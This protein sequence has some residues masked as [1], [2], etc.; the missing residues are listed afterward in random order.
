MNI[1][2]G[3]HQ[4]NREERKD[5]KN[6]KKVPQNNKCRLCGERDEMIDHRVSE[7][8]KLAQK[9]CKTKPDWEGKVIH[10]ELCKRQK[11]NRASK[12]KKTSGNK[13][14]WQKSPQQD[15]RLGSTPSKIL[16]TILKMN[17]RETQA[18]GP[19]NKEMDDYEE[20]LTHKR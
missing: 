11:F 4:R 2:S 8:C 15:K 1:R 10:W 17:Q 5:K 20:G 6:K 3:Q 14:L 13:V 19:K 7:C 9:E 12:N 16:R 18:N